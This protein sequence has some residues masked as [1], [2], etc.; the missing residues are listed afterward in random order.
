MPRSP[1]PLWY[2]IPI[3]SILAYVGGFLPS[4]L[5]VKIVCLRGGGKNPTRQTEI[6]LS[7]RAQKTV[8][9]TLTTTVSSEW[10]EFVSKSF[11]FSKLWGNLE[12]I[13]VLNYIRCA[14]YLR[15]TSKES[16][17]VTWS[18]RMKSIL[19]L[20]SL[21]FRNPRGYLLQFFS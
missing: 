9:T 11:A 10:L 20:L 6:I 21:L 14:L 5:D 1:T 4:V 16:A 15:F 12:K 2:N 7:V 13:S 17:V 3:R 19:L 8:T 18:C